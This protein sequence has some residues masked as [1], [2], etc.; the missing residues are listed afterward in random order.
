[1]FCRFPKQT[2]STG[3]PSA[4][5]GMEG[6]DPKLPRGKYPRS[7]YP[8][9]RADR[10]MD[11]NIYTWNKPELWNGV[12]AYDGRGKFNVTIFELYAPANVYAI[13]C[14]AYGIRR[15]REEMR[16]VKRTSRICNEK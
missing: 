2:E 16:I 12:S 8:W 14:T 15:Q 4:S 7:T 10:H 6:M 13:A 9:N 5:M 3:A 1:M 11:A